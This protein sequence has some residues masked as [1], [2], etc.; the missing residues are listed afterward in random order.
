MTTLMYADRLFAPVD[1]D[2][3][4][5]RIAG[6]NETEVYCT[7]DRRHVVKVKSA[8]TSG[9]ME[10]ALAQARLLRAA[11]RTFTEALGSRYTIPNYFFVARDSTG[12]AKPVVVQPYVC[13]AQP[14]CEIDYTALSPEEREQVA[15]Q[16]REIIR[17]SLDFYRRT[18]QMPDLYGRVSRNRAERRRSNSLWRLP[19]RMWSFL[20]QRTLLRSH[21]LLL[22]APPERRILLVD[23]DPVQKGRLYRTL[24][25]AARV[26]LF[27]RDWVLIQRMVCGLRTS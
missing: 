22:T 13:D 19:E 16:L 21:N 15:A 11:A 3:R 4:M 9:S 10:E 7:D 14:L 12:Q 25:Y 26:L 20:V 17:R 24:Y 27:L 5:Q 8:D 23:Y 1:A 18:G 6:G 2:L